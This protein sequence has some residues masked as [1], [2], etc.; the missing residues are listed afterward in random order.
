MGIINKVT[1]ARFGSNYKSQVVTGVRNGQYFQYG[2]TI[3]PRHSTYREL[4]V[5]GHNYFKHICE[6]L[7]SF[8]KVIKGSRFS[9]EVV[10]KEANS[11]RIHKFGVDA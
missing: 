11:R 10:G 4:Y 9:E 8:G 2:K 7:D 5:Q 3:E 6:T 1:S